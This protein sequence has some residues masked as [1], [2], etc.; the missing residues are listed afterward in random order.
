MLEADEMNQI[1]NSLQMVV[2]SLR[3]AASLLANPAGVNRRIL[4]QLRQTLESNVLM[5]DHAIF[6]MLVDEEQAG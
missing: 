5:L 6:T 2:M 1:R 4:A 3:T